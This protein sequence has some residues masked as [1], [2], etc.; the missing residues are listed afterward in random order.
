MA[1]CTEHKTIIETDGEPEIHNGDLFWALRGGG[2]GT[3][4]IVVN[5]VLKLLSGPT[6]IVYARFMVYYN[7]TD[8]VKAFLAVNDE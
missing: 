5:Y 7:N 4:G 8:D 3:F 1:T 6:S 2:G